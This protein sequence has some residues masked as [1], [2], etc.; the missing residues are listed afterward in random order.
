MIAGHP[1][2]L[3]RDSSDNSISIITIVIE[4]L[5]GDENKFHYLAVIIPFY[6]I[7]YNCMERSNANLSSFKETYVHMQWLTV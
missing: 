3:V 5:Y 6:A 7:L 4:L 2:F 1:N